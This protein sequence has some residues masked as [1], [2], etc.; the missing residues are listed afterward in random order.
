MTTHDTYPQAEKNPGR[1][2]EE[3][4]RQVYGGVDE[5]IRSDLVE[6]IG[7]TLPEHVR[8]VEEY[9]ITKI[10]GLFGVDQVAQM[11]E[12]VASWRATKEWNKDRHMGFDGN[13]GEAYLP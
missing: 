13:S 1:G 10:S 6:Q 4:F 8:C 9:G 2:S 5:R 3:F 7:G 11:Q 12:D